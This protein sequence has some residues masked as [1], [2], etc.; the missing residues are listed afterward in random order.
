MAAIDPPGAEDARTHVLARLADDL[1]ETSP[2]FAARLRAVAP[3]LDGEL[4][5]GMAQAFAESL[6]RLA[7]IEGPGRDAAQALLARPLADVATLSPDDLV[8]WCDAAATVAVHSVRAAS[9]FAASSIE[10][11][12]GAPADRTSR[13]RDTAAAI[14]RLAAR[15]GGDPVVQRFAGAAGG[16]WAKG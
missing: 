15:H 2:G 7:V 8:A 10:V 4:S 6:R 1:E 9:T 16:V 3:S 11:L 14:T 12:P 5:P 13:L